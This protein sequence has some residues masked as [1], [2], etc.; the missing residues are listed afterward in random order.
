MRVPKIEFFSI[1][2]YQKWIILDNNADMWALVDKKC[3][4]MVVYPK[5][6][7]FSQ[8]LSASNACIIAT[9][10]LSDVDMSAKIVK[11][12]SFAIL[13]NM[14]SNFVTI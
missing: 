4:K 9:F 8:K 3:K 10:S 13:K 1:L 7:K 12:L 14:F 5:I 11:N 2:S 6:S